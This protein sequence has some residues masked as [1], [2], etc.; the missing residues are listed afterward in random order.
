MTDGAIFSSVEEPER[1][2]PGIQADWVDGRIRVRHVCR[3]V[4]SYIEFESQQTLEV[5]Q[6]HHVT[7]Q[8]DGRMQGLAYSASL[9]GSD[10]AMTCTH[11]V[12]NDS[13]EKS[14]TAPLVI[15]GSP[16]MPGVVGVLKDLRFYDRDLKIGEVRSL[17]DDRDHGT[18]RSYSS[19]RS[20]PHRTDDPTACL[21]GER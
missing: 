16:L 5:G 3:W 14:G 17:A 12:T 1:Y 10:D 9:D 8:C 13:A 7:F 21:P 19:K 15:G 11:P 18:N 20:P 6:W 4:N 2:R